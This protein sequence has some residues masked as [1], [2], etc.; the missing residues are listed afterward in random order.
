VSDISDHQKNNFVPVA[1]L[2]KPAIYVVAHKNVPVNNLGELFESMKTQPGRFSWAINNQTF[3]RDLKNISSDLKIDYDQLVISRFNGTKSSPFLAGGHIDLG[4]YPAST[5]T[6]FVQSGQ[7]KILGTHTSQQVDSVDY[8]GR[9]T[10]VL[11]LNG[12]G[13]FLLPGSGSTEI[14]FWDKFCQDFL[15]NERVL[16]DLKQIYFTPFAKGNQLI[17]KILKDFNTALISLTRREQEIAGLIRI[18]GLSNKQISAQLGIGESAVKVHVTKI[19]KKY[20]LRSRTQLA[21]IVSAK[22]G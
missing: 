11:K 15:S 21:A 16:E 13:L 22:N 19:L 20:H 1:A 6:P 8:T 10:N 2:G 4:I 5:I 12:F 14:N 17:Q 7:V 18:R 9:Y 3:D